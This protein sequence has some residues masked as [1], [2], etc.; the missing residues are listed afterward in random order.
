MRAILF[1]CIILISCKNDKE[2][3]NIDNSTFLSPVTKSIVKKSF[4]PST[5]MWYSKPA[6]EWE[7]ALPVG[8][9]RLG[10]MVFGGIKEERIQL[11]EDTYWSGGPYSTVVKGGYKVLPKIQKLIFEGKP[12]EAHKLFGR[13]LMGYPV[14]QQKYQSLANLHLFFNEDQESE[15]YKRWLDLSE[16]ITGVEYTINGVTYL[17]EVFSSHTDQ[18]IAIRLTASEPGMISFETELR[19]V[20]NSAHSNYA[21]DYFYMDG[22]GENEL[23]LTGKSADYLG[24]DG[25]LRYEARAQIH[26]EGGKIERKG[27]RIHIDNAN[28][29]T[30]YF[31]AATNFN[32]Y[33]DVSGNEK[34]RVQNYLNNL[35]DKDYITIRE[36]S[37][38][39]YQNLFSRVSLNLPVTPTSFLPTDE[40]MISIQK[41]PDPQMASLSYQFGRYILISS[42]RPGTQ[43][44]NL[45]G[46]WNEDMNPSW[47][48]KYTTN[49]NTEM[50]YWPAEASNLSELTQPLFKMIE[51][52]TDQGSEV[53]KEHYG[54]KGWVFHQ[55][56]DIWRVAAPMDGPTWGTFTVG[57]AWLTTHLWEHYLYTQDINFLKK[58][59]PIIKGSVDFFMSFL[60][61]HP[62][63]KWLVTN[64]S[65]SPE[66][67]PEG[68]G[69][70]YFYDEVTG[71]YYFTTI[72]AGATMDIQILKDLFSYYGKATEILNKDREYADKVLN[73]RER[74]VPSQVGKD[75]TLQEW[76]EDFGQ[77]EDKHRHFSHMYGL[78][79]GNVLSIAKTPELIDPIKEVLEQRGDGGTGFSRAWKMALWARLL[80]GDR[81]N[82]IYKGYLQEQCYLS[83][84][85]K[86]YTPLQ[87]DGTLGVTA[88]ISEMLVQSH[89]DVIQLLPAL[90]K[91]WNSGKF[92]GVC[93]RGAF[94]L[95]LEWENGV[96]KKVEILSKAGKKC[97]ISANNT[98]KVFLNGNQI[99]SKNGYIEFPTEK[100]QMYNLEY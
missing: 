82:S 36:S 15:N 99:Q 30:I 42:S 78:F 60:V 23:I 40:R 4:N 53:A 19:G 93:T 17:R 18:T 2:T 80:D 73:A 26:S 66:N 100:G 20:R 65:N 81:A 28:S 76:M 32:N 77:L 14:E 41:D 7:K 3:Q 47:D 54:S 5:L 62:N 87:V 12:I 92:Y 64:P 56:T 43:P 79:P 11:N 38:E 88:A 44:T 63:G 29:V 74:L 48:S 22:E 31:A 90:P 37:I 85:A 13:H 57:G 69:Y 70:K 49:I 84:F 16:G 98:I 45:Q 9:G 75:G 33:K 72:T 67:P 97:K 58:I 91:E 10:A 83:L 96:T 34:I 52:L 27:T 68:P 1:F 8:N 95:N 71:M 59:Y 61:E 6:E 46:I 39:D 35:K 89:E 25:K 21:T 50:N 55:N 24:I 51:E 86:C 94:E